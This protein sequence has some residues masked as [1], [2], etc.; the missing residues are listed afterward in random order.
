VIV[1]RPSAGDQREPRRPIRFA[2]T[3]RACTGWPYRQGINQKKAP[4]AIGEEEHD[5]VAWMELSQPAEEQG[6]FN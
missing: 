1:E 5:L 2:H 6:A 4:T 3:R